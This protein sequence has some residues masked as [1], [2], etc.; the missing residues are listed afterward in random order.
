MSELSS[1]GLAKRKGRI[2]ALII[3]ILVILISGLIVTLSFLHE[4]KDSETPILTV[5]SYDNRVYYGGDF[6][7]E[8]AYKFEDGRIEIP[9]SNSTIK[10]ECSENIVSVDASGHL[11]VVENIF[12]SNSEYQEHPV[13]ITVSSS[14]KGVASIQVPIKVVPVYTYSITKYY[15]DE[16]TLEIKSEFVP[17][18]SE[19]TVDEISDPTLANYEFDNWYVEKIGDKAVSTAMTFHPEDKYL[20]GDNITIKP[21]FYADVQLNVDG[22]PI[23]EN[24]ISPIRVYYDEPIDDGTFPSAET[25]AD[26][27]TFGGWFTEKGGSG[28]ENGISGGVFK[29]KTPLLYAKWEGKATLHLTQEIV[30]DES[31]ENIIDKRQRTV[32]T[33]LGGDTS[34]QVDVVYHAEIK[35]EFPA[36]IY[37]NASFQTV[38][39]FD[40]WYTEE[41]GGGKYLDISSD[42]PIYNITELELFDKIKYEVRIV[43]QDGRDATVI[44]TIYGK[45]LLNLDSSIQPPTKDGWELGGYILQQGSSDV[46]KITD[47]TMYVDTTES[48]NKIIYTYND[49]LTVF[50]EWH[51]NI[52]LDAYINRAWDRDIPVVYNEELN[53]PDDLGVSS[54]CDWE[55]KG[56]YTGEIGEGQQILSSRNY[57]GVGI[58]TLYG[59]W[60]MDSIE[61]NYGNPAQANTYLYSLEY[62][63]S[64][65]ETGQ[66]LP[67]AGDIQDRKGYTKANKWVNANN[68]EVTNSKQKLPLQMFALDY[69]WNPQ[70]NINVILNHDAGSATV[71]N[72]YNGVIK[73]TMGEMLEDLGDYIPQIALYT[74]MGYYAINN[75]NEQVFYYSADMT[76]CTPWDIVPTNNES[77]VLTALWGQPC[78]VTLDPVIA[79]DASY[80]DKEGTKEVK[81]KFDSTMPGGYT[82]PTRVGYTFDGYYE[83]ENGEG[84]QYYNSKM[85]SVHKWDKNE[86]SATIYAYWIKNEISAAPNV[87]HFS[88]MKVD[89]THRSDIIVSNGSG[90]YTYEVTSTSHSGANKPYFESSIPQRLCVK[91]SSKDGS[92]TVKIKVTDKRTGKVANCEV[93]YTTEKSCFATGTLITLAD[94]TVKAIE[95]IN[96]GDIVMSWD[97]INGKLEPMA[98]SMY[99]NHGQA[100]YNVI[101]LKFSNGSLLR[102]I[103][104][105]GIFDLTTNQFEYI[106]TENYTS[107][108]G[109]SFA[110]IADGYFSVQLV[111]SYVTKELTGCYSLETVQNGNAIAEG[112]LTLTPQA[113]LELFMFE[114]VGEGLKFDAEK[115]SSDIA[116]YGLYSYDEWKDY[117][118]LEEFNA[119][120]GQ[121]M[122][123]IVGKGL[124]T[125]EQLK[126]LIAKWL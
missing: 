73:A 42:N 44:D 99:W 107:Y 86:D 71:T 31:G 15:Y 65:Q 78:I 22:M 12:E 3:S 17:A 125:E 57:T 118:T 70:T 16:K 5:I 81:V 96:N 66:S 10:Y 13:V 92:G 41:Y 84:Q 117:V 91:A 114:E 9:T 38:G 83:K 100:E 115:L 46:L 61:L 59:Y 126:A 95:D 116:E 97:F 90:K 48:L 39:T 58:C 67:S 23:A 80:G 104:S 50:V 53:L 62:G 20:W 25:S 28:D 98:V 82:A 8:V 47:D 101:N 19:Q 54:V 124:I 26:G 14:N 27:W 40:G 4:K 76:G 55:L 56:W 11:K 121:Y 93:T 113:Y 21:K 35:T 103:G 64:I 89:S 37:R 75:E 69:V 2:V 1:R 112:L 123:I 77:I 52:H 106:N 122:K 120:N 94:G 110:A 33:F 102:I 43:Y 36:P 7:V 79:Y 18:W 68:E 32:G 45:S 51:G 109:H 72:A 6:S 60:I 108:I 49:V 24:S 119:F 87:P 74:F 29:A 63:K 88:E 85:V 34:A 30:T 105:H 111:D